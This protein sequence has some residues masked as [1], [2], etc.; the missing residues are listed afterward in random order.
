MSEKKAP[1]VRK[2]RLLAACQ[3]RLLVVEYYCTWFFAAAFLKTGWLLEERRGRL[4]D[5]LS[6]EGIEL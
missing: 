4:R 1:P 6:N 2:R 5:A 3:I